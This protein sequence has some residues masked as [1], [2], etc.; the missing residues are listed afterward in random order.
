MTRKKA[1]D[2]C[3]DEECNTINRKNTRPNTNAYTLTLVKIKEWK[4]HT[5]IQT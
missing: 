5:Y 2:C 4:I 1:E 3:G